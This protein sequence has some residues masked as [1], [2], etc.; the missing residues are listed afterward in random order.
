MDHIPYAE[1]HCH[2]NASFLDGASHPAELVE[3]AV[4]LGLEA[5]ALTDH[6]GMYGVVR[7]AEAARAHGLPTVFGAEL[8]LPTAGVAAGARSGT[9]DPPGEHLVVLARD[10][11]G[12][13]R[14]CQAITAAQLAGSKGAPRGDLGQFA[15][16]HS[17]HWLVLTGCRKGAVPKAL[18][19]Q[20]PAAAANALSRLVE[21]FGRDHLM[22]ELWDHGDPLDS[23]RNDA[24]VRLASSAGIGV[25]A[26]NNVHYATP[27]QRRLATALAAVRARCSLDEL[28]GWLPAAASAHLRSGWEQA[29]RLAR[30]PGAVE[31]AAE[32]G[33]A[34][35]FDLRLV[36]PRLPGFPVPAGHTEMSWLRELAE[37]GAARRYGPRGAERIA[38]AWRQIDHELAVIE[39]LGFPGY[40]LTVW[41]I[42]QFC[43]REDIFCQGR[44]SAAN[45]AVCYAIGITKADAVSLGL[46][47]ERFLSPERDGPSASGRTSSAR[48]AARQPTRPSGTWAEPSAT[49]PASSTPG[50]A[51]STSGARCKRKRTMTTR[52]RPK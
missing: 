29:R 28:D 33:R 9:P 51:R 44:G 50:P 36:A 40:F 5:L 41:D 37:R 22:V 38:G 45:S 8:T 13:A 24:L 47:F 42:V 39:Q 10:P 3:E 12:Y 46:L 25:V 17:G 49:H 15:A 26:T 2:S 20:G 6:D 23:A 18:V 48:A 4:R 14:L 11:E 1:L 16:L 7:F 21:A 52:F 27:A 32:L 35:A 34:L 30:Y 31:L 19:E 43:E